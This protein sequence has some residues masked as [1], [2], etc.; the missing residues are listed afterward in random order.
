M[1]KSGKAVLVTTEWRGV[2]FGWLVTAADYNRKDRRIVL[3]RARNIIYWAG[4]HGFLGLAASGPE[5]TSKVGSEAPRV[6]LHGV[7]SVTDCTA[8]AVQAFTTYA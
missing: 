6:E 2:F 5:A 8:A 1:K 3:H 4:T 7:T